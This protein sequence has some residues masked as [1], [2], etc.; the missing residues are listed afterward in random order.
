MKKT[1]NN[2]WLIAIVGG[3]LATLL[4]DFLKQVP[5]FSTLKIV[6]NFLLLIITFKISLWVIILLA[7]TFSGFYIFLKRTKKDEYNNV[8]FLS[9]NE[10]NFK[11]KWKWSWELN[12]SN[13]WE[14]IDLRSY[15]PHC[16]ALLAYSQGLFSDA[17]AKCPNCNSVFGVGRVNPIDNTDDVKLLIYGKAEKLESSSH[18][19][20]V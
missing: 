18:Y 13:K 9:Y 10:D 12:S 2:V 7:V 6:F 11:L 5:L 8:P 17:T 1:W 3:A 4:A 14:V 19:K 20:K 16:D 15:C